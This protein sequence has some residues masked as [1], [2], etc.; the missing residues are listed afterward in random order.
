[1]RHWAELRLAERNEPTRTKIR[2][3]WVLRPNYYPFLL[4]GPGKTRR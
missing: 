1:M 4:T 3:E 2:S